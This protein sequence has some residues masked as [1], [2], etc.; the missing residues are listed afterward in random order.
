MLKLPE[1]KLASVNQNYQR[2]RDYRSYY[3]QETKNIISEHLKEDIELFGYS[4]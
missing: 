3:N 1:V 4:F 2:Q